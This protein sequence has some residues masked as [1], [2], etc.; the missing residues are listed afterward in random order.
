M[1]P[2]AT[3]KG[4]LVTGWWGFVR[5]PNYLGD[6][7]MALAWSLPCGKFLNRKKILSKME[8]VHLGIWLNLQCKVVSG[9]IKGLIKLMANFWV[10]R[11]MWH[12]FSLKSDPLC[13]NINL[14]F[15]SNTLSCSNN[16]TC[17]L[18]SSSL[19]FHFEATARAVMFSKDV[20]IRME[21]S[22]KLEKR[23]SAPLLP[24]GVSFQYRHTSEHGRCSEAEL[25]NP[26][27]QFG[28][29]RPWAVGNCGRVGLWP[30]S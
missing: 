17:L 25:L 26:R 30:S 21:N 8:H 18:T 23:L 14:I 22:C 15:I 16:G 29:C 27:A 20:P 19:L 11:L 6:I 9:V 13:L 28:F 1:I 12:L 24:E 2:T 5:H 3:G 10:A 7:I 4:L